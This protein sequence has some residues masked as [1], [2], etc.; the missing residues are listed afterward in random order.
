MKKILLNVISGLLFLLAAAAAA[1]VEIQIG[2]LH[3][4]PGKFL[5][6]LIAVS[7]MVLLALG[8]FLLPKLGRR[9]RR[10]G[11]RIVA[12]VF[13]ALLAAGCIL[14]GLMVHK[15]HE[16]MEAVTTAPDSGSVDVYVLK[17]N[18]AEN[19]EQA[20]GLTFGW[21]DAFD[22][23]NTGKALE[24]VEKQLGTKLNVRQYPTVFQLVNALY[25]GEVDAMV[26]NGAYLG[27]LEE[28][29]P[30]GNFAEKTKV[31]YSYVL[32]NEPVQQP[33]EPKQTEPE[34][35]SEPE[36]ELSWK[37]KPFLV[38]ISGSDTRS[39]LLETSR[40]DVNILAAVNPATKQILLVNTPRDYYIPNPAS[41]N[42]A[43]DKLTHC[44]IYGIDTSAEA[45]SR[46]YNVPVD[47]YAQINFTGFETLVDAV[48]GVTVYSEQAFRTTHGGYAIQKGEN[49]MDGDKAL[50]FARERYSFASGDNQRGKN[51]MKVLTAVLEK[52]TSGTTVITHY[53][54]ILDSLQGMFVTNVPQECIAELVKM[55]L[56]DMAAWDIHSYAVSGKCDMR[57]T[58]SAPGYNASIMWPDKN[59]VAHGHEL[60][61]AVLNGQKITDD[62]V[63]S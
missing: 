41:K 53:G 34:A 22:A 56:S 63:K 55:Q 59:A 30:Y 4:L 19:L 40:S 36:E 58:F 52:L 37:D 33:T 61:E 60:L 46:L 2:Q 44:G 23:E 24:A 3:M 11:G 35:S 17:K 51:Q 27:I 20:A 8:F 1:W 10:A 9:E 13:T 18:A 43:L 26:L 38:Y 50:C 45:L 28:M 48:G 6:P 15:V 62:M 31:I 54:D 39:K 42:G 12:C 14:G 57:P 21:S 5:Y 16:T 29:E 25:S 47:Y 49:F 32:K 7:V